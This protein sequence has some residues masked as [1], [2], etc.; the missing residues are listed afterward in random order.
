MTERI[1]DDPQTLQGDPPAIILV[2]PQL[3]ENIGMVARAMANFGL[4]RLRIVN[5]RDGWPNPEAKAT[6]SG[7]VHILEAAEIYETL[8][9]ALHDVSRAYATTARQHALDKPVLT[10]VMAAREVLSQGQESAAYVFGRERWGLVGDEVALCTGVVTIPVDPAF[11]SLNLAQAVL[12]LS[13]EWRRQALSNDAWTPFGERERDT[14]RGETLL[15]LFEHLERALDGADF[16]RPPEK[17]PH[18]VRNLRTMLLR[19]DLS[20]QEARTL[21]GVVAALEGRPNRRATKV[22]G[23][24]VTPKGTRPQ[25]QTPSEG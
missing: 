22:K 17:R 10:P 8:A 2:E 14:A 18:M 12:L 23:P 5:P 9:D 25:P 19:A 15:G 6:S 4:S 20:E 16:F 7:A 11:A 1:T 3:G 21:R 24:A 13:Y